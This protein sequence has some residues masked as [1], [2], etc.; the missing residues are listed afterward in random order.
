MCLTLL[1]QELEVE[2]DPAADLLSADVSDECERS[3]NLFALTTAA[4]TMLDEATKSVLVMM[5]S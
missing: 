5:V 1:P 4:V 2:E 3:K